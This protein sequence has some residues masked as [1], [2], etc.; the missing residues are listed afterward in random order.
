MSTGQIY[1][2][3]SNDTLGK[4]AKAYN[5]SVSELMHLNHIKNPDRINVGQQLVLPRQIS[6]TPDEADASTDDAEE[7][8]GAL[9]IQLV[10]AINRPIHDLRIKIESLGGLYEA[11]T[12][13]M[14][15][16]PPIA[17]K[18]DEPV[19]VHV[20]RAQGGMKHVATIVP[21]GGAQHAR[22][23]SPKVAVKASLRK[24][25]GPPVAR[26]PAE[27]KA[28]GDE[29]S[30]R[31]P[32]GNP[33]HEVAMECPNPQDLRLVANF[34]YRDIIIAAAARIGLSPQAVA[35][36][37]NTESGKIA[38]YI[39]KPVLDLV[40]HLPR[41]DKNGKPVLKKAP[42]PDWHEG[43]WDPTSINVRSSA[44][45]MTQFL[46]ASWLGLALTKGL[47]LNAKVRQSGWL[48]AN[49][50][51][52]SDGKVVTARGKLPLARVLSGR[53][54]IV[55][56]GTASDANLQA[57]LD[58]RFDPECSIYTAVDYAQQNMEVLSAAGYS[59]DALNDGE[60][61]KIA[62]LGHHL[63]SGD[64]KKFIENTIS[65]S[66]AQHLLER[67]V[68][69]VKAREW[70]TQNNGDYVA[71]HRAWL[72]WFINNNI[73][74]NNFFCSGKAPA[75]RTL[76]ALIEVIKKKV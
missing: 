37:I 36:I 65:P 69:V 51:N 59:F 62:Y 16:L 22:I 53:P 10:D 54:Y 50:F 7:S 2:V 44:R 63:G 72:N 30:T 75:A 15:A 32:A 21:D 26:I 47:Y 64:A 60:K 29:R 46:D 74:L 9:V 76:F 58:L 4:I 31:S 34:K 27:P 48:T 8:W 6:R 68:G 71:G 42:N 5:T 56:P 13:E 35:A 52:L 33:V 57:L 67:Q 17:V 1:V 61:A 70:A 24:H 41:V 39:Q 12:N 38:Q 11:Q 66:S 55:G 14:G 45:G 19:K 28:L 20:A 73:S 40:T 49:G 25:E 23:I 43:A 18:R 3:R